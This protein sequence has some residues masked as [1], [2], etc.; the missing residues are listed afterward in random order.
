VAGRAPDGP[1]ANRLPAERP[2]ANAMTEAQ[3]R[4]LFRILAENGY[5][6]ERAK[7]VICEAVG[8]S[9]VRE[10]TKSQA[11]SLIDAWREQ[12]VPRA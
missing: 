2:I 12:G 3:R 7:Q 1:P 4:L 5:E 11:S 8:V 6:G 9:S 10:V